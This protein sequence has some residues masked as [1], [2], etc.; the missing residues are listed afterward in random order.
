MSK[1]LRYFLVLFLGGWLMFGT[2][3]LPTSQAAPASP[4]GDQEAVVKKEGR[5]GKGKGK[6]GKRKGKRR[7]KKGKGKGKGKGK[8]RNKTA[9]SQLA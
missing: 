9:L 6:K 8:K 1:L 4:T 3:G 7:G 2:E 5:K